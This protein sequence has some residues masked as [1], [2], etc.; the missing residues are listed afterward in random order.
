MQVWALILAT[1]TDKPL[2][3]VTKTEYLILETPEEPDY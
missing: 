3:K 2:T 1:T